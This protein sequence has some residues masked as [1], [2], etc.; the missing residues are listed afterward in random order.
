MQHQQEDEEEQ[1]TQEQQEEEQQLL[2]QF[3]DPDVPRS[4]VG[5]DRRRWAWTCETHAAATTTCA[6]SAAAASAAAAAAAA[7]GLP[8]G[9]RIPAPPRERELLV[10]PAL[11]A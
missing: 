1:F 7:A 8:C 2:Q 6:A 3:A 10:V 9:A 4:K 11:C 5:V